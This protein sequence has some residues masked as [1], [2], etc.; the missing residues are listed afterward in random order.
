MCSDTAFYSQQR[1]WRIIQQPR[2]PHV[3]DLFSPN[4]K[5][6]FSPSPRGPCGINNIKQR[7]CILKQA[8]HKE[9]KLYIKDGSLF[10]SICFYSTELVIGSING[11]VFFLLKYTQRSAENLTGRRRSLRFQACS[12]KHPSYKTPIIMVFGRRTAAQWGQRGGTK[13]LLRP[14]IIGGGTLLPTGCADTK[15][16]WL[17]H[18]E[19]C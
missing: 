18:F 4:S 17:S 12:L 3:R 8:S 11:G 10:F 13:G 1:W 7:N 9:K 2:L 15:D 5:G 14:V 16:I 6:N 19:K